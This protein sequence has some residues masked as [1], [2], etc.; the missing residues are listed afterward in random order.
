MIKIGGKQ[1]ELQILE[2][3]IKKEVFNLDIFM[4][5]EELKK[6]LCLKCV[7]KQRNI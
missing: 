3:T 2:N 4:G 5:K 1:K 7:P 6:Q